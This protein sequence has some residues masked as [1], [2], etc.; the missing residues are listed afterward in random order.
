MLKKKSIFVTALLAMMLASCGGGSSSVPPSTSESSG[1][2]PSSSASVESS[3]GEKSPGDANWIYTNC[4][5]GTPIHVI[6]SG[7]RDEELLQALQPP[8][9]ISQKYDPTEP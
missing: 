2:E 5:K 6:T 7:V 1:Q 9:L 3:Q 4:P 8:A